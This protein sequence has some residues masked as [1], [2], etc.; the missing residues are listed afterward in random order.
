MVAST[1]LNPSAVGTD[2][3]NNAQPVPF[4]RQRGRRAG[5]AHVPGNLSVELDCSRSTGSVESCL[6]FLELL[7]PLL[8]LPLSVFELCPLCSLAA[9]GLFESLRDRCRLRLEAVERGGNRKPRI[10]RRLL[11]H[12]PVRSDHR[13][14]ASVE[15][16]GLSIQRKGGDDREYR[17]EHS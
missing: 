12:I 16:L 2:S 11:D 14:G 8:N 1:L 4:L 13:L 3:R 17:K 7:T 5:V 9:A 6:T 15:V 10:L